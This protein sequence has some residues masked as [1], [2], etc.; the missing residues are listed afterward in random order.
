MPE[1]ERS[2]GAGP[3]AAAEVV[4][5]SSDLGRALQ[6]LTDEYGRA[7]GASVA[8]LVVGGG[9]GEPIRE[10]WLYEPGPASPDVLM[11]DDL[12]QELRERSGSSV[13]PNDDVVWK[14]RGEGASSFDFIGLRV[15]VGGVPHAAL[16]AALAE[17]ADPPDELI[18]LTRQFGSLA[19]MCLLG[20]ESVNGAGHRPRPPL[21]S[22]LDEPAIKATLAA[23]VSRCALSREPVSLCF[24]NFADTDL[25]G[26]AGIDHLMALVGQAVA[27]AGQPYDLVG[28]LG[29]AQLLVVM[30]GADHN[31]SVATARHLMRVTRLSLSPMLGSYAQPAFGIAEWDRRE[32]ADQLLGRGSTEVRSRQLSR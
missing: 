32:D 30:P 10:T 28:R 26:A 29:D 22:C 4:A 12:L 5:Q 1:R 18:D 17:P 13:E 9:P 6:A 14:A 31:D 25:T 3:E 21:G 7:A 11:L 27:E 15:R 16:C 8:I 20:E 2:G 24:I 23:E 19:S